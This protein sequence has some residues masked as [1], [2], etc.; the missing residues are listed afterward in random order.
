LV[1]AVTDVL[2]REGRTLATYSLESG[3]QGYRPLREFLA[4]KLK[5]Q[6][7]IDCSADNILLT[8]GSL[9]G[10]DL[11][12]QVLLSRGDTVIIEEATYGGCLSRFERLGVTAVGV[13]LDSDGMR[14]DALAEILDDLR[15][16]GSTPKFIYAIPTIQNPTA[17]IMSAERRRQLLAL[18][19]DH[20]V[21]IVE[22]ECYSDLIWDGQRPPAV[23][24]LDDSARVIFL[25]S[26][27]KSIAPALRV[28]YVVAPWAVLSRVLACKTDAGSGALE[29]MVLAE[30]CARHFDEHVVALN[31]TLKEKL[32]ALV[33]ALAEYFGAA[34]EFEVPKGGIFLWVKLPPEVDTTKLAQKAAEAGIAINPGAEWSVA[35]A[36]GRRSLRLC[37]ANPTVATIRRGVA[38]LAEVSNR[39]FGVPSRIANVKRS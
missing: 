10:I 28:G 15:Q 17:S 30:Y 3:P 6:A 35:D 11:V 2:N 39:E 36:D 32:D 12:N 8:S 13:P 24:S 23:Y 34:A 21:P 4:G 26:F 14:M 20:G 19:T 7:G 27:S 31:K 37:Y 9:Q 33:D 29:Q 5:H 18:A 22:D 25:G 16:R 38:A 1:A